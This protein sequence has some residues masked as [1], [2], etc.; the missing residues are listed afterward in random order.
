MGQPIHVFS[1]KCFLEEIIKSSLIKPAKS[2]RRVEF[3]PIDDDTLI[4]A[5]SQSLEKLPERRATASRLLMQEFLRPN[6]KKRI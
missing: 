5:M 2:D 6:A 4:E 1:M 3:D